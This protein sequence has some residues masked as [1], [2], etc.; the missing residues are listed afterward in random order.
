VLIQVP[1]FVYAPPPA[2]LPS[3]KE[4]EVTLVNDKLPGWLPCCLP[5]PGY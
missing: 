2:G 3:V 5:L 1:P 4:V